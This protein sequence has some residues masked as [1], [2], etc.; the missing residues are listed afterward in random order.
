MNVSIDIYLDESYEIQQ[1]KEKIEYQP[2]WLIFNKE[3]LMRNIQRRCKIIDF[4]CG[5]CFIFEYA[6]Y[7]MTRIAER[8]PEIGIDGGI[9]CTG[10]FTEGCTYLCSLYGY[11]RIR[12]S[13]E[14][15]ADIIKVLIDNNLIR[16]Q[17]REGKYGYEILPC[18]QLFLYNL[19]LADTWS[20]DFLNEKRKAIR[21]IMSGKKEYMPEED[22]T[23]VKKWQ[24]QKY[25]TV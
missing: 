10:G 23:F 14:N 7:I 16:L 1:Q 6:A 24:K 13:E 5:P 9:D 2:E 17:K 21:A 20:E 12:F 22:E 15:I 11:E 4:E 8:F 18:D 3:A 19:F 25:L